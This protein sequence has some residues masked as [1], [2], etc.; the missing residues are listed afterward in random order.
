MRRRKRN[1]S[2]IFILILFISIGFAA[3]T[4]N[5]SINSGIT[6]LPQSFNIYFDNLQVNPES[7]N[8]NLPTL[9]NNDQEVSFTTTINEPGDFY[10]FTFDVVNTGTMDAALDEIIKSGLTETQAQYL[11][12]TARYYGEREIKVDDILHARYKERVV[13][14]VEYKYDVDEV[15]SLGNIT[16]SFGLNYIKRDLQK[17]YGE[18]TWNIDYTGTSET[19]TAKKT[20]VYK[21][22]TWG[23]SGGNG[24][25]NALT[26]VGNEIARDNVTYKGG[27]GGYSVGQI[28]LT[29]NQDIFVT[30]GGKGADSVSGYEVSNTSGGYNGGGGNFQRNGS[31]TVT[32]QGGGATHVALESGLLSTFSSKVNELILVA[33]GGGGVHADS[34]NGGINTE[35]GSGGGY[36]GN[37]VIQ[38]TESCAN[39]CLTY[40]YPSGGTQSTGGISISNW[41]EGTTST[42]SYVGTFGQGAT[43][44][45]SYGGGGGGFYGGASG[46]YNAGA[47]GSGYIGN[48]SLTNKV[49]YCYNC[50]DSTSEADETHIKTR[51]TTNVSEEPIS[52]YA[53]KG[54]GFAR[55][56]YLGNYNTNQYTVIN[57]HP[58]G[59]QGSME[60]Q[61]INSNSTLKEN[62]YTR[63][64]YT[65]VGWSTTEKELPNIIGTIDE[66]APVIKD[67][68]DKHFIDYASYKEDT[69]FRFLNSVTL[70]KGTNYTFMFNV[71]DIVSNNLI[72]GFPERASNQQ[73]LHN[74]L[75]T[76]KFNSWVNNNVYTTIVGEKVYLDDEGTNYTLDEQFFV[77]NFFLYEDSE[78]DYLDKANITYNNNTKTINLYALW[79]KVES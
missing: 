50:Q 74:G 65:F 70:Q 21:I 10:E 22:E 64:G 18:E 32:T 55:I 19:F 57:Y 13:V 29:K 71:K 72:F 41:Y 38:K 79:A 63:D 30:A 36:I 37:S 68:D 25:T 3:L 60:T 48:T 34:D 59:G 45:N 66:Q 47:G 28:T 43:A 56:T 54:N 14:R 8:T 26:Y 67:I 12:Y 75:N 40:D 31:G 6:F 5:L 27:Y 39:S 58:N 23:A 2:I 62:K 9:S 7:S 53:K 4:A 49:M 20:G 17:N 61:V 1:K 76:Y 46:Q 73:S 11:D 44:I 78:I 51:S 15:V 35:G 52:N 42:T 69:W 77:Y 24:T 33:G 16:F